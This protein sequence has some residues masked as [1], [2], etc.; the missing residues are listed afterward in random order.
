MYY[1]F[2]MVSFNRMV[3]FDQE[4]KFILYEMTRNMSVKHHQLIPEGFSVLK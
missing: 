2:F 1:C 3:R 4:H